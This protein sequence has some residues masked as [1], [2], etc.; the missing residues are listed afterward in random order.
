M[1][2]EATLCTRWRLPPLGG[3]PS[4]DE[5]FQLGLRYSTGQG[6]VAVDYIL[7]HTLFNLAALRGSV[8]AKIYRKELGAE[9]DPADVAE[10]QRI[11]R[12]WLAQAAAK[13][14]SA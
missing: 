3:D 6:D 13:R 12:E 1:L 5:L 10:A 14:E 11:A 9:M 8:E 2:S 7:A 4:G